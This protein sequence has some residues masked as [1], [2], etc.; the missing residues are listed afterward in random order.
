V[1][2]GLV[3]DIV[4]VAAQPTGTV[5]L[6]FSDVEGSTRLLER[7]GTERY[8][9]VL[10]VHRRLLREAFAR[11]EGYEVGTEGDSFFVTFARAEDAVAAAGE[12]QQAL[13]DGAWPDDA[14]A[15]VRMGI[16]TGEPLTSEDSYVGI[17]V[18]RAARIMAAAHG[19]QVLVS[20]T[21]AALVD[22]T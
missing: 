22:G 9:E 15:R 8:A 3:A 20:E 4:G 6:L 21:T 7:L 13:A 2:P 11:H 10:E 5:T 12:A 17:D 19:A 18:H 1:E 14:A 16:H